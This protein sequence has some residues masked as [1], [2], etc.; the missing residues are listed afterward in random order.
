MKDLLEAKS[1]DVLKSLKS[2]RM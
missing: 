1:L 2:E